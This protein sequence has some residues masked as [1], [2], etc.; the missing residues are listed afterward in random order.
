M[1]IN[2]DDRGPCEVFVQMGKV[3]GCASAQLEALARLSSLCLR[4]NV[5]L[6]SI[7]RQLKGI[8]C[9]SPMWY[10]GKM[11]TSC[12]DAISLSLETFLTVQ[13]RGIING[14][15]QVGEVKKISLSSKSFN[16]N[17]PDCGCSIEH[18]E[19]CLKCNNCGWSKC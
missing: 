16:Q 1:T 15:I 6:E 9:P 13:E 12:A 8:R 3:G 10:K 2:S 19:G 7:I 5:K 11:I 4:A 18:S 14:S 17:C